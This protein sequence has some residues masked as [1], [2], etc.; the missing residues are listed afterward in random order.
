MLW[1]IA[2][3]LTILWILG[4][5]TSTTLGGLIHI[6]IVIAYHCNFD[7]VLQTE[8]INRGICGAT[9]VYAADA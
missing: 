2:S 3:T 5:I 9:V 4:M 7:T 8:K 1:T 6:L